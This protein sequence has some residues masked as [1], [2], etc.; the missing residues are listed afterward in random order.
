MNKALLKFWIAIAVFIM[1]FGCKSKEKALKDDILNIRLQ[2]DAPSFN[3]VLYPNLTGREIY[4]FLFLPLADINENDLS[5]S[6]VLIEKIPEITTMPDGKYALEFSIKKDAQWSDG[7]PVTSADVLF[8][9][10]AIKHSNSAADQYR[11]LLEPLKQVVVDSVNSQKCTFILDDYLINLKESL[12]SLEIL[13]KH[14]IDAEGLSDQLSLDQI[15]DPA[16]VTDSV[17]IRL[18]T[19][20][21]DPK[22]NRDLTVSSGP[23]KLTK[24]EENVETIL[25]KVSPYWGNKYPEDLFQSNAEKMIFTII[26]DEIAALS[27]LSAG[28]IDLINGL[29]SQGFAAFTDTSKASNFVLNKGKMPRYYMLYV[30][31]KD[32][33]LSDVDVRKAI[34]CLTD[35]DGYIKAFED[36]NGT[37]MTSFVPPFLP[38]YNKNIQLFSCAADQATQILKADGWTDTNNNKILDKVINNKLTELELQFFTSGELSQKIGLLLKDVCEKAGI[39]L[40][41]IQKDFPLVMKENLTTGNYSIV[42]SVGSTDILLENPYD[43]YHS[44][45]IGTSNLS[46]YSNPEADKLIDIIRKSKGGQELNDAFA[47]LQQVI[48]D[49]VAIIYLYS[50]DQRLIVRDQWQPVFTLK[51][52]GYKGN[53]FTSK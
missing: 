20:L 9:V 52:P 12:L 7:T 53:L 3:P 30:N 40:E 8:T 47:K 14:F 15:M 11:A 28:N 46:N 50:P 42:P 25:E 45:N 18:G 17:F 34:R 37:K 33:V 41:L 2:K 24:Y 4:N 29:S 21:N 6:P 26:P 19:H 35:V 31:H 43:W 44:D 51:R 13:P 1:F 10:K 27:E 36:G 39:K 16:F 5:L 22:W 23:Y 48:Y 49:D 38:G 32:P